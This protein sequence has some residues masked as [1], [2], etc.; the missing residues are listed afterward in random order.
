[1][2]SLG[3]G[4]GGERCH[5]LP[6]A[7]STLLSLGY[8][9]T[10]APLLLLFANGSLQP[11]RAGE[12]FRPARQP[13]PPHVVAQQ[14][15][16]PSMLPPLQPPWKQAASAGSSA[17]GPILLSSSSVDPL[18]EAAFLSALSSPAR[19]QSHSSP[20]QPSADLVGAVAPWPGAHALCGGAATFPCRLQL[21]QS[22]S[23]AWA[24]RTATTGKAGGRSPQG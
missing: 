8:S 23:W 1:M 7:V 21:K 10:S 3:L 4:L 19:L 16:V 12:A 13:Q 18:N 14:R 17:P 9:G 6:R 15:A 24:G 2:A 20:P 5:L 22:I 11:Y